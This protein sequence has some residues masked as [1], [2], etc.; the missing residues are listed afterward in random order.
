MI[1]VAL[2]PNATHVLQPLDVAVFRPVKGTW[3][4]VI[5]DFRV[6]NNHAKLTREAFSKSVQKCF[7]LSL[8]PD[9][10][11]SGFQFCGIYPFDPK[12]INYD[13][14]LEKARKHARKEAQ[15]TSSKTEK[16]ELFKKEFEGRLSPVTL[17][18][19]QSETENEWTGDLQYKKLFTFW[20]NMTS[21]QAVNQPLELS[22]TTFVNNVDQE[23]ES[24]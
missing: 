12:N 2:L 10:I 11:K 9:T 24:E 8:K 23:N 4:E 16:D 6:E 14:L 21:C 5:R 13:K 20:K 1:L 3:R 7:D 22:D 19:F 17:F 18:A 15:A